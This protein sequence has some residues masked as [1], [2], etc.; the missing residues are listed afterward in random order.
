M[1]SFIAKEIAGF[2]HEYQTR[3]NVRTVWSDPLTAFADAGD[4]LFR[5]LKEVI[6]PSH[7]LP[8]DLLPDARTVIV[9]FLPFD[10]EIVRGN[11]KGS[12]AS[13]EWARAYVETNQLIIELNDRLAAILAKNG[14]QTVRLP[15]THNF[16]KQRLMSDWSHKH[17][18]YI[19]GLGKFGVHHLLITDKGCC[20]RL[21]SV[22]IDASIEPTER[23]SH[24]Y[25]LYRY[26]E[27]CLKCVTKCPAGALSVSPFDRHG[28]Y[29]VLLE[30]AKIYEDLGLA[31]V[32]GKCTC[33]VPCSFRN[34]VQ[35]A[36][37]R[38]GTESGG[39]PCAVMEP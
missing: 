25:C 4:P 15:P 22:I 14:F 37:V 19:A 20:G 9:Y 33:I 21:G 23:V 34:P 8:G 7:C 32:C 1:K 16:D 24:E 3:R 12:H 17:V 10:K 28:C 18:A 39:G 6:G 36:M 5:R 11:R 35:G 31:D 30:N 38:E 26:N 2:V 27:T 13:R 29:R